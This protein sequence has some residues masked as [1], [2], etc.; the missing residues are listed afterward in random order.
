MDSM[1]LEHRLKL[2]KTALSMAQDNARDVT[3]NP[4]YW[5]TQAEQEK[6]LVESLEADMREPSSPS[7]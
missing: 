1:S 3:K 7:P 4:T 5:K 2:A 6:R